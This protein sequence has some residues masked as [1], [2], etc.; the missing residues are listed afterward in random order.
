MSGIATRDLKAFLAAAVEAMRDSGL[1]ERM[2][3]AAEKNERAAEEARRQ[4]GELAIEREETRRTIA[5]ERSEHEERLRSER[6]AWASEEALRHRKLES[7]EAEVA[8]KRGWSGGRA[9]EYEAVP[10]E[11]VDQEHL[12][13]A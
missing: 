6:Q 3:A 12:P 2:L 7:A 10:A 9:V 4:L 8:R 5:R 13:A 1:V 11:Q